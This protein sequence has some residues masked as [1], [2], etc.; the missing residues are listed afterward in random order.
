MRASLSNGSFAAKSAD[1]CDKDVAYWLNILNG[2]LSAGNG[3]DIDVPKGGTCRQTNL[4][5]TVQHA[6]RSGLSLDASPEDLA[7]D[8]GRFSFGNV[9]QAIEIAGARLIPLNLPVL[10]DARHAGTMRRHKFDA[11]W[12][13]S[14]LRLRNA[15]SSW[16]P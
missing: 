3:F 12:M 8:R 1:R 2:L 4:Q 9:C 6:V 11:I 7:K 5:R 10:S 14:L 13:L 15:P 16:L